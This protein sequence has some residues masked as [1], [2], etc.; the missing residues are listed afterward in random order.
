MKEKETFLAL[1]NFFSL[2][3]FLFF[4]MVALTPAKLGNVEPFTFFVYL[5]KLMLEGNPFLLGF[6][7]I[8]FTVLCI[9]SLWLHHIHEKNLEKEGYTLVRGYRLINKEGE[10]L[11]VKESEAKK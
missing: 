8:N 7:I 6:V 11:L 1:I 9:C 3:V 10:W 2:M 4:L 5:Q